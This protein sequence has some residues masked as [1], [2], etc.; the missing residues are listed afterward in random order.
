MA[1]RGIVRLANEQA[2]E[3]YPVPVAHPG[4]LDESITDAQYQRHAY[5]MAKESG[6][7]GKITAQTQP[8]VAKPVQAIISQLVF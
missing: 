6:L 7:R 8:D 4:N 5:R 1:G 3:Q 2:G